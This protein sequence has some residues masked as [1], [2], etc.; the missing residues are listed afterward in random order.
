MREPGIVPTASRT[1]GTIGILDS[2]YLLLFL[3]LILKRIVF[4]FQIFISPL[5]RVS[6]LC[7]TRKT[8][9]IRLSH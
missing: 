3:I 1:R 5:F 7:H 9:L 8:R 4:C 2:L 6:N